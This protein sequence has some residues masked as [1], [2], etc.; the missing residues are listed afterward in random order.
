MKLIN[1]K[2]QPTQWFKMDALKYPDMEDVRE[3]RAIHTM[4]FVPK[5]QTT[6]VPTGSYIYVIRE[7]TVRVLEYKFD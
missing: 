7:G 4:D 6:G 2:F 3:E 5:S 1:F